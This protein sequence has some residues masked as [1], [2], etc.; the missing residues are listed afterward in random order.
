[1]ITAYKGF[2]AD[3]RCRGYQ[4][5]IGGEYEHDGEVKACRSGFHACPN[6]LDVFSYYPPAGSRFA[7]VEMSGET[8]SRGDDSK[9]AASRVKII[10]EL[11]LDEMIAAGVKAAGDEKETASGRYGAATASGDF[12]KAR[13]AN[14]CALFA[15]ERDAAG[16][17]VSVASG[18]VGQGGIKPDTWYHCLGGEL[19]EANQ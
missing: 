4:Y 17:I 13:G 18:I 11:S 1:M 6:P 14:G 7:L 12:C 16:E 8:C 10:R 9:I 2:D 19:V 15:V 5:E 3:L